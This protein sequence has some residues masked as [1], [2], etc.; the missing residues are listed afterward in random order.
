M[1]VLYVVVPLAIVLAAAAVWGFIWATR[2]GQYDDL[3]TPAHRMLN[4]D[5]D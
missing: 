2:Q 4:D 3:D 1:S 5:E